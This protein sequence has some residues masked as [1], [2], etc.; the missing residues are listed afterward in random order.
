MVGSSSLWAGLRVMS[1]SLS[2][3]LSTCPSDRLTSSSTSTAAV[4]CSGLLIICTAQIPPIEVHSSAVVTSDSSLVPHPLPLN[5][6]W[7]VCSHSGHTLHPIHLRSRR[8]GRETKARVLNVFCCSIVS[9]LRK[10]NMHRIAL[11]ASRAAMDVPGRGTERM[12]RET[13]RCEMGQ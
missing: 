7:E 5:Q 13:R 6:K 1:D 3:R 2:A 9:L 11:V 10:L 4:L 12:G 8:G